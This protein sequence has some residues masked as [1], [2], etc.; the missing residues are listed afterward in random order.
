[1]SAAASILIGG[2]L[3][4]AWMQLDLVYHL[5]ERFFL[6]IFKVGITA[7]L[8][9]ALTTRAIVVLARRLLV[10]VVIL[11]GLQL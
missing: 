7:G 3:T 9:A 11:V 5:I 6:T 10:A 4:D 8:H 1:M 2:P